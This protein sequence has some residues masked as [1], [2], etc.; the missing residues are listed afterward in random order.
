MTQD[1]AQASAYVAA[2]TGHAE[3]VMDFRAIH[4]RDKAV[5]AI[6]RRGSL[7]QLWQELCEWNGRGYGIFAVVNETD[8]AGRKLENVR[9]IRAHF[10]DL[11]NLAAR[12]NLDRAA[13][14]LIKPAFGVA[15]SPNKFHVYFPVS[16]Y[17]NR[18]DFALVQRKLAQFFESDPKIIDA[19]HVMRVPGFYHCKGEPFLSSVFALPGYGSRTSID[20]LQIALAGVNVISGGY[21]LR[22]PLG[23]EELA[24]PSLEWLEYAL[25]CTDPNQLDRASWI[26]LTAAFKQSGWTLAEQGRLFEIWSKWCARY[27]DNDPGENLKQWNDFTETQ[28]GWKSIVN[29]TPQIKAYLQLG[30][31]KTMPVPPSPVAPAPAPMPDDDSRPTSEMLTPDE[32]AQYFKGCYSVI[33]DGKILSPKKILMSSTQFNLE[34][35]GKLF[36]ISSGGKTTD[37]PYKAATRGTQF[38]IPRVDHLR[39]LPHLPP[40]TVLTDAIGRK[41]IN[42]YIPPIIK[43]IAGDVSRFVRH[44]ELMIPH[45]TDRQ[46]FLM[47]LAANAQKPG[48]KI[49]WSILLQS[50]EG[51]GKG[52]FK[53]VLAYIVGRHYFYS[54]KAEDLAESGAKFNAWMRNKL[55]IVV[56]EIRT[57]ERRDMIEVLKPFIS[58]TEVEIQGKGENQ[59]LEDNFT[60]W[61]FFSNYKDA[62]PIN[63]NSRR[64]AIIYSAIQSVQDLAIRGMNDAYFT[65]LREWMKNGGNAAIYDWLM[66][67]PVPEIPARAPLTSSWSEA[68]RKSQ[69]ALERV[70]SDAIADNLPGFRG[71]WVSTAALA[72]RVRLLGLRSANVQI[73]E[74]IIEDAGFTQIGR[75]LR[76]YLA[77]DPANRATLYHANPAAQIEHY[78]IAQGYA[79]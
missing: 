73:L 76:T 21:G 52:V 4:D 49:P 5:P 34:Y 6:I 8:G 67:Y 15:S 23:D 12:Q 9:S 77:E 1:F 61:F 24:A 37:E 57:H 32:Q 35:G 3:T 10:V 58:E 48:R 40:D 63:G 78:G 19:A 2:L 47:Y 29:R 69:S 59:K 70:L 33:E 74:K 7:S 17:Q 22:R 25:N 16:P 31:P 42:V 14:W 11:D 68:V 53:E 46:I 28:L 64:Y 13:Q 45:E 43:R 56:D 66:N 36:I 44:V 79:E 27:A 50:A 41:G 72:A 75:A 20:M 18:D 60:N 51:A 39:F 38:R 71:G 30:D 65:D 55:M 54:P 62:I 26:S